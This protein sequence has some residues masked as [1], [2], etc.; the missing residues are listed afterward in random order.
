MHLDQLHALKAEMPY[1]PILSTF[2]S[3]TYH[4][5]HHLHVTRYIKKEKLIHI[6]FLS[7]VINIANYQQIVNQ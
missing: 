7:V 5:S 2:P 4:A 1:P 3:Q 6:M